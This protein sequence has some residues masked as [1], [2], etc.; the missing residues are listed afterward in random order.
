[1][2]PRLP[3]QRTSGDSKSSS[4]TS[5][6]HRCRPSGSDASSGFQAAATKDA[7]SA[8]AIVRAASRAASDP[9]SPSRGGPGGH[10]SASAAAVPS[11]DA[12]TACGARAALCT[13]CSSSI[14]ATA[15]VTVVGV[16]G[17]DPGREDP[18]VCYRTP[19]EWVR[20]PGAPAGYVATR[21]AAC[22]QARA[23]ITARTLKA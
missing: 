3:S 15:A 23:G 10:S 14:M 19:G 7:G 2:P 9:E 21:S 22:R 17:D 8:A 18:D 13:A 16:C 5:A 4:E 1:M 12:H 20:P 11:A 6:A